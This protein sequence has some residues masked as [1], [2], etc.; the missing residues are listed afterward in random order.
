MKFISLI[1]LFVFLQA[2]GV[3]QEIERELKPA[4]DKSDKLF[5]E[6]ADEVKN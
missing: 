6:L 1:F 2:C 3:D 5:H 4:F